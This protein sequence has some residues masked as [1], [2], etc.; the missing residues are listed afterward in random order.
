MT[1]R[2]I[3]D[4]PPPKD[5]APVLVFYLGEQSSKRTWSFNRGP[6]FIRIAKLRSDGVWQLDMGGHYRSD[7]TWWMPLP[8]PPED[9]T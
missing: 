3:A 2:S 7:I 5:G 9:K 4:D 8:P 6:Q 1:W